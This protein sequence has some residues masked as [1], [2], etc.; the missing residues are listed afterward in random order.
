MEQS[1]RTNLGKFRFTASNLN[2][3]M[4]NLGCY[5][6]YISTYIVYIAGPLLYQLSYRGSL[7]LCEFFTPFSV[8]N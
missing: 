2:I 6:T 5:L 8:T 4:L 7:I 3:H 1:E